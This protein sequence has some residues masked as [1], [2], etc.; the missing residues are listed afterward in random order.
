MIYTTYI[1]KHS[2][3]IN[4]DELIND[5]LN[6]YLGL[7]LLLFKTKNTGNVNVDQLSQEVILLYVNM[8]Y[9]LL[10]FV[11]LLMV[12]RNTQNKIFQM[13]HHYSEKLSTENSLTID[14]LI[15]KLIRKQHLKKIKMK[16]GD[17]RRHRNNKS[18]RTKRRKHKTKN[19]KKYG[20]INRSSQ[21]SSNS[22]R[23]NS[24]T[25]RNSKRESGILFLLKILMI[26]WLR[27]SCFFVPSV[28][29]NITNAPNTSMYQN[30]NIS[31]TFKPQN[32]SGILNVDIPAT[33]AR[34]IE[35]NT[36]KVSAEVNATAEKNLSN[37]YFS[38]YLGSMISGSLNQVY[39][40]IYTIPKDEVTAEQ[41]AELNV[42][43]DSLSEALEIANNTIVSQNTLN[44]LKIEE[45]QEEEEDD[46]SITAPIDLDYAGPSKPIP[47]TPQGYSFGFTKTAQENIEDIKNPEK[48]NSF[49]GLAPITAPRT[50]IAF[51]KENAAI[52]RG[53]QRELDKNMIEVRELCVDLFQK[54]NGIG[55]FEDEAVNLLK[56]N[57]TAAIEPVSISSY[58]V[59]TAAP[60][61]RKP[62]AGLVAIDVMKSIDDK[63]SV[64][65]L[66]AS[67]N[68]TAVDREKFVEARIEEGLSYCRGIFTGPYIEMTTPKNE[69]ATAGINEQVS[70]RLSKEYMKSGIIGGYNITMPF[71]IFLSQLQLLKRRST[72]LQKKIYEAAVGQKMTLFSS[73]YPD[74]TPEVQTELNRLQDV[75]EKA[76]LFVE[77]IR[78]LD[79]K[80]H[81]FFKVDDEEVIGREFDVI[82]DDIK[83][84]IV[85]VKKLLDEYGSFLPLEKRK[86]EENAQVMAQKELTKARAAR[87]VAE[88][89]T[90]SKYMKANDTSSKAEAQ[91][92]LLDANAK[93]NKNN[94][95]EAQLNMDW[96]FTSIKGYMSGI[97]NLVGEG[98]WSMIIMIAV[99]VVLLGGG[100]FT[101]QYFLSRQAMSIATNKV[102][103]AVF[104][105]KNKVVLDS[106]ND[107]TI[108]DEDSY[109]YNM[110]AGGGIVKTRMIE[111]HNHNDDPNML[112]RIRNYYNI[113]PELK[114]ILFISIRHEGYTDRICVRFK[115]L[116][117]TKTKLLIE[118]S[119]TGSTNMGVFREI[120]YNDTILDPISNPGFYTTDSLFI[121]CVNDFEMKDNQVLSQNK[122][123]KT[124]LD[125]HSM[126]FPELPESP[127]SPESGPPPP[128]SPA[129]KQRD[130][131]KKN[132]TKTLL[133]RKVG[134]G[135]S[136][137]QGRLP[138]LPDEERLR[139]AIQLQ[140]RQREQ[141]RERELAEARGVVEPRVNFEEVYPDREQGKF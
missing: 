69:N 117:S 106:P 32:G 28:S 65:N 22:S 41:L 111:K 29:A 90:I 54:T 74:V 10:L 38:S 96:M 112:E 25:R 91:S 42:T 11:S 73:F 121:R 138:N 81:M 100:S 26:S 136:S 52:T 116:N 127:E 13:V 98:I 18:K 36:T 118:T 92:R 68:L 101:V 47:L 88:A 8:Q 94:A 5:S 99:P 62:A 135:L 78:K 126:F 110:G 77:L 14:E 105:S 33:V 17:R 104:G 86:I 37:G 72:A 76:D 87:I 70:I 133:T 83:M 16:G 109:G 1:L 102:K 124:K 115:G 49:W 113:H 58:F 75:S 60:K 130:T 23:R 82:N 61:E 24:I 51:L 107:T 31:V 35:S 56:E 50:A 141:E 12:I 125:V 30:D 59:T 53:L 93:V 103:G 20:S 108:V 44:D 43:V 79:D 67:Q 15:E 119:K 123:E 132:T 140:M 34:Q 80:Q 19:H 134:Q 139:L 3:D 84:D 129:R 48:V 39:S 21:R 9:Q 27:L 2:V 55:L 120:D 128:I 85:K 95:R 71:K 64:A 7:S 40:T 137:L 66:V 57:I 97:T 89:E 45:E 63:G 6:I 46:Y 131:Y 122:I 114:N 4:Y